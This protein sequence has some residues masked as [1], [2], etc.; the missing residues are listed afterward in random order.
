VVRRYVVPVAAMVAVALLLMASA[1]AGLSYGASS[2]GLTDRPK[3]SPKSGVTA[4]AAAE[5]W[6]RDDDLQHQG[7]DTIN[8]CYATDINGGNLAQYLWC[9][10]QADYFGSLR[11]RA[12]L[13]NDRLTGTNDRLTITNDRLATLST[14]LGQAATVP[15]ATEPTYTAY[16]V[17]ALL[18][19]IGQALKAPSGQPTAHAQLTE[20]RR[21][22]GKDEKLDPDCT[23]TTEDPCARTLFGTEL[24]QLSELRL[25]RTA[26]EEQGPNVGGQSFPG[27]SDSAPSY[28]RLASSDGTQPL[29]EEAA[30]A[31]RDDVWFLLGVLLVGLIAGPMLRRAFLP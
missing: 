9:N 20:L 10:M 22:M 4:H 6:Q 17:R 13:T 11:T 1:W 21:L 28:V 19:V 27:S 14:Q 3:L 16:S 25:I 8:A 2:Y 29:M 24:Q 15:P 23:G 18:D 30:T 5:G 12:G 26:I 31:L 7:G